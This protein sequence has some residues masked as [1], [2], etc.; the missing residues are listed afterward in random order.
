MAERVKG[1]R[2]AKKARLGLP[3][4]GPRL[5][6]AAEPWADAWLR[7]RLE[8][9]R[10]AGVDQ[11]LFPAVAPGGAPA[12]GVGI[13]SG[14]LN[15]LARELFEHL[16]VNGDFAVAFT[17]HSCK[18]TLLSWMAKA[19]ES[20]E[21]RRLLGG[22]ARPGEKAPLEYSRDALAGPLRRATRLI[23]AVRLGIFDPDCTRSGRWLD[24]HGPASLERLEDFRDNSANDVLQ[25]SLGAVVAKGCGEEDAAGVAASDDGNTVK[26]DGMKDAGSS[27]GSSSD[28]ASSSLSSSA[29]GDEIEALAAFH[30]EPPT[31]IPEGFREV[32]NSRTL[33]RHFVDCNGDEK[34]TLCGALVGFNIRPNGFA[35]MPRCLRCVRG[36]GKE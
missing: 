17:S 35:F 31:D 28:A 27:S 32:H 15:Y 36:A 18:A 16:G 26:A 6:L 5:G 30:S 9:G 33:K 29:S 4:V 20:M 7:V 19:G 23:M 13:A 2:G 3:V 24:G 12:V 10:D 14:Q 1:T 25:S 22:H 11:A 21:A 8:I 34:T